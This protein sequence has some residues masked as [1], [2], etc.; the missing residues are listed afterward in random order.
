MTVNGIKSVTNIFA[1]ANNIAKYK[2]TGSMLTK[3]VFSSP[4]LRVASIQK[5]CVSLFAHPPP[6]RWWYRTIIYFFC[7]VSTRQSA[8][9]QTRLGPLNELHVAV[10]NSCASKEILVLNSRPE[11][12]AESKIIKAPIGAAMDIGRR[13]KIEFPHRALRHVTVDSAHTWIKITNA[14][15]DCLVFAGIFVC[16]FHWELHHDDRHIHKWLFCVR[17]LRRIAIKV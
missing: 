12:K 6:I 17:T 4:P 15:I 2:K 8:K 7:V 9:S 11:Q 5:C 14:T 10:G 1:P 16:G 13:K 3:V